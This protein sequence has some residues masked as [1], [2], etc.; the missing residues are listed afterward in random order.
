MESPNYAETMAIDVIR[1][2]VQRGTHALRGAAIGAAV[3]GGAA[4][5]LALAAGTGGE[6][7]DSLSA[8][9]LL[10]AAVGLAIPAGIGALFGSASPRWGP[11]P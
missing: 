7:G 11:A 10:I 6:G 4:L 9:N 5:L 1:V 2:E 8:G 3:F